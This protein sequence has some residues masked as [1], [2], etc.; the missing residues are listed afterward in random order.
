[1]KCES[2]ANNNEWSEKMKQ[3]CLNLKRKKCAN[4]INNEINLEF[5]APN[6]HHHHHLNQA[7]EFGIKLTSIKNILAMNL[8]YWL[9]LGNLFCSVTFISIHKKAELVAF[10]KAREGKKATLQSLI[11][12]MEFAAY[13]LKKANIHVPHWEREGQIYKLW[14]HFVKVNGN[15]A[16]THEKNISLNFDFMQ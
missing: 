14:K 5:C 15:F 3:I 8:A 1:M 2:N 9:K 6:T 4:H 11:I 16:Q 13:N 7:I 10:V 12:V